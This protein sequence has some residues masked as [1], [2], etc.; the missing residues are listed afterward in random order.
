MAGDGETICAVHR[1]LPLARASA[2]KRKAAPG[3]LPQGV[4]RGGAPSAWDGDE[5]GSEAGT[6][7]D[8]WVSPP[9]EDAW[10]ESGY[11]LSTLLEEVGGDDALLRELIDAT[12]DF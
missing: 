2:R 3:G 1:Y 6:T 12:R 11:D 8:G 7:A 9:A 5:A 4:H 10:R